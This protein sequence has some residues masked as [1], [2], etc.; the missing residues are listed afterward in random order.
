MPLR[1]AANS[2]GSMPSWA[3]SRRQ[4]RSGTLGCELDLPLGLHQ[5]HLDM[6]LGSGL[7]RFSGLGFMVLCFKWFCM[8]FGASVARFQGLVLFHW[9]VF[10]LPTSGWIERLQ[11][12]VARLRRDRSSGLGSPAGRLRVQEPRYP[13]WPLPKQDMPETI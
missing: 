8:G 3:Q 13:K 6:A 11:R 7:R 4:P 2:A 12:W 1:T 10:H 9:A 5:V